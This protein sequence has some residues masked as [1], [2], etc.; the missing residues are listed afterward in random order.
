MVRR[1]VKTNLSFY[2]KNKKRN[3]SKLYFGCEFALP[4]RPFLCLEKCCENNINALTIIKA[5]YKDKW[6]NSIG[7]NGSLRQNLCRLDS[8]INWITLSNCLSF[9]NLP[10]CFSKKNLFNLTELRSKSGLQV[11]ILPHLHWPW[12]L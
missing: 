8:V 7:Q 3:I 10:S 1:T 4:S 6:F 9:L 5:F 11:S 12:P 2:S